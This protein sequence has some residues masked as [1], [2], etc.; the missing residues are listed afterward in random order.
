MENIKLKTGTAGIMKKRKN[1]YKGAQSKKLKAA[2]QK[3]KA[4]SCRKKKERKPAMKKTLKKA[5]IS[6]KAKII[7]I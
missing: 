7:E 2:A 4:R 6:K 5:V 3:M 1:H